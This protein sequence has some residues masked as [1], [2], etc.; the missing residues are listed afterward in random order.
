MSVQNKEQ[1]SDN[2]HLVDP[3]SFAYWNV[4]C[5]NLADLKP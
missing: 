4:S 2:L 3:I 1:N 5:H